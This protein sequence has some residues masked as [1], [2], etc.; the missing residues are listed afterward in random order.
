MRHVRQELVLVA[1]GD[2]QLRGT[3][4]KL[5]DETNILDRYHGLI[6]KRLNEADLLLREWLDRATMECKRPDEIRSP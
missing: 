4:L 1:A 2:L 5:G 6:S 3:L